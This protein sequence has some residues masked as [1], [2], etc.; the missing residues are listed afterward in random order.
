MFKNT[1]NT[2]Q[3]KITGTCGCTGNIVVTNGNNANVGNNVNTNSNT[4]GNVANGGTL[5]S[6]SFTG[7]DKGEHHSSNNGATGGNG[8]FIGTGNSYSSGLV[9]NVVNTNVTRISH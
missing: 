9:L 1:V 2:N 8:G 4:G 3:T 7:F 5:H 6:I